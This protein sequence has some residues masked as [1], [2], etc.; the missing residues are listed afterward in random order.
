MQN[1][2]PLLINL[3]RVGEDTN[4]LI[5]WLPIV[6]QAK[7]STNEVFREKVR[8]EINDRLNLVV[9]IEDVFDQ[10]LY[11]LNQAKKELEDE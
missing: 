11:Y 1:T 2:K 10:L 5:D 8:Q 3:I 9:S 7:D 6:E 4:E